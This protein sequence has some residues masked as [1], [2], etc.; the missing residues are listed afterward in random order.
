[1]V[2]NSTLVIDLHQLLAPLK[3]GRT[4]ESSREASVGLGRRVFFWG[5]VIFVGGNFW[6]AQL[7]V[8]KNHGFWLFRFQV[9][10]LEIIWIYHSGQDVASLQKKIRPWWKDR[11]MDP[12]RCIGSNIGN[13]TFTFPGFLTSWGWSW[14]STSLIY[15]WKASLCC[16]GGNLWVERAGQ[17]NDFRTF[18]RH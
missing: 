11:W 7:Y 13:R 12:W 1:M 9:N 10:P 3:L 4:H 16:H 15:G 17:S 14:S 8:K 18:A 5:G 2:I 6:S